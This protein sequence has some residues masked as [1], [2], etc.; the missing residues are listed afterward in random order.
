MLGLRWRIADDIA[1][2]PARSEDRPAARCPDPSGSM[3]SAAEV[4][5]DPAGRDRRRPGANARALAGANEAGAH[6][7]RGGRGEIGLG[8]VADHHRLAPARRRAAR[9]RRGRSPGDGLPTTVASTPA[10]YSSPRTNMPASS[11]GPV[12]GRPPAVALHRHQG[13]ALQQRPEHPVQAR[14]RPALVGPAQQHH[15]RRRCGI[16]RPARCPPG[17]RSRRPRPARTRAAPGCTRRRCSAAADA[18]VTIRRPASRCP[19]PASRPAISARVRPVVLVSTPS[20][21]PAPRSSRPPPPSPS[22]GCQSTCS[23]PSM[24]S[25]IA[26]GAPL[27]DSAASIICAR[28]RRRR[29]ATDAAV[30]DQHADD[31][32]RRLGRRVAD[33]P[34]V[35]T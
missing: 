18:A 29:R 16:A 24:S 26:A 31:H 3:P 35:A 27:T 15:R 28:Y 4:P 12:G 23:T 34:G 14:V 30:H 9:R 20:S 19:S 13:P 1:P 5:P 21:M 33:E 8:V 2:G 25:T 11:D 22:I 7:D 17:R 32:P 6:A 10:A